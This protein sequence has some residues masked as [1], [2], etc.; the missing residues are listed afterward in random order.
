[1]WLSS[2]DVT[3]LGRDSV[4]AACAHDSSLMSM[5]MADAE[6]GLIHQH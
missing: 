5:H 2:Q 3:M 6:K 4:Q 1:M